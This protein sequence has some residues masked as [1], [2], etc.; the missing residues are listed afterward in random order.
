ME[1]LIVV[2]IVP[3]VSAKTAYH[4][5]R[6]ESPSCSLDGMSADCAVAAISLSSA[7]SSAPL[8]SSLRNRFIRASCQQRLI[9]GHYSLHDIG[10]CRR[11][12][13]NGPTLTPPP[14][15]ASIHTIG[16]SSS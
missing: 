1:P 6:P 5:L 12:K 4:R 15:C 2:T 8:L 9:D 14:P 3:S 11:R 7:Q 13:G 10:K 16:R